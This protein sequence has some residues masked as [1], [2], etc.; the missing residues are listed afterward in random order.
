MNRREFVTLLGGAAVAWPLAA[1]AQQPRKVRRI[2]FLAGGTRP[3]A[4]ESSFYGGFAKGMRELGYVEARDYIIEWRFAEG[5]YEDFSNL[6][7]ELVRLKVDVIVTG[8]AMAIRPA[9]QATRTIPIVMATSTD[10][11]GNGFVASLAR[12]GGNT[13]GLASSQEDYA[14]KHLDLLMTAV[15]NLSRVGVLMN[16]DGTSRASK[17]KITLATAEK[18]HLTPVLVEARDEQD[19]AKAFLALTRERVGAVMVFADPLF[20]T[21]RQQI[22]ELA[23]QHRLPTI[24][25][26]REYVEA[27]G[28]MSYGESVA[29]FYRRSASYVDKIFKGARPAD[30]PVEQPT[31]F[32]FSI[33]RKTA[34]AIGVTIPALFFMF[35]DEMIE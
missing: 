27:G 30:L 22:A 21:Q 9:Q 20:M 16:P 18:A 6:A 33:N 13:T 28:L 8:A 23:L 31:R 5:K 25:A 14:P 7:A 17:L 4:L 24:F 29:E 35:A 1:R 32:V 2:G 12:P 11:V 3:A 19:I 34:E 10:P 15:P 26:R